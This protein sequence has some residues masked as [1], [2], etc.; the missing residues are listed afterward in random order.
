ME[1]VHLWRG[2]PEQRALRALAGRG[3]QF[4]Y[5][6]RQLR[7]P[8]WRGKKVL[9]FGGSDGRLLLDPECSIRPEDYY[10]LDVVREAQEEGRERFP[11]AHWVH[12]DRYNCSFNPTGVPGLAIPAL[13]VELDTIVAYSVFTHTTREDMHELTTQLRS[14]L[15]PGGVLAFTFIDPHSLSWPDRY[16]GNNLQWR[17]ERFRESDPTLDV[18]GLLEQ[19]R[20]AEWCALVDGKALYVD[21]NGVWP[22]DP[23]ACLSYHVYYT[24]EQ[25]LREFPDALIR[26]QVNGEMQHCCILGRSA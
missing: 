22:D 15:A 26:P 1:A 10:C 17:L 16:E 19:S 11:E 24:P 3:G 21:G 14:Q 7:Y 25:M 9:D 12:Y 2:S 6:D 18:E 5:F 23:A 4:S 20:G 13:G 8:Q